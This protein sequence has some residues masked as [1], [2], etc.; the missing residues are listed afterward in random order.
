MFPN[1]SSYL[2]G[3]RLIYLPIMATTWLPYPES[4]KHNLTLREGIGRF[5]LKTPVDKCKQY[6]LEVGSQD[7]KLICPLDHF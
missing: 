2:G 1:D 6:R 5:L 3:N 7:H 4:N